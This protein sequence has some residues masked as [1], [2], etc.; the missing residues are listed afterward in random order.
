VQ[1]TVNAASAAAPTGSGEFLLN[2]DADE[3]LE[4]SPLLVVIIRILVPILIV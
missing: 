1:H 2:S 4:A 3:N